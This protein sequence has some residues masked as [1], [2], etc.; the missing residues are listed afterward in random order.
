MKYDFCLIILYIVNKKFCK[1]S[2]WRCDFLYLNICLVKGLLMCVIILIFIY[3]N[4]NYLVSFV[5]LCY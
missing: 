1:I 3:S 5:E 4:I 2:V